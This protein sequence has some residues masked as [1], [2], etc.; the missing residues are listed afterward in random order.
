MLQLQDW[1][2]GNID[3]FRMV[4]E[5]VLFKT[6][7]ST[8][9]ADDFRAVLEAHGDEYISDTT[10]VDTETDKKWQAKITK[11]PLIITDEDLRK[12]GIR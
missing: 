12:F 7:S 3:Q 9:T 11:P 5:E 1:S 4:V 10:S 8:V 2:H 6:P